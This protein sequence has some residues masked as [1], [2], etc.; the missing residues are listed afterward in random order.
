MTTSAA[1]HANP[2]VLRARVSDPVAPAWRRRT[3]Y[4]VAAALFVAALP[5][6]AASGNVAAALFGYAFALCIAGP[7]FAPRRAPEDVR[8]ELSHGRVDLV[9]DRERRTLRARGLVGASTAR[10]GDGR[11]ALA[12]MRPGDHAPMVLELE[13]EGAAAAVSRA[14]GIGYD[15]FG[16]L[17]WR[18]APRATE[19]LMPA[20]RAICAVAWA[21]VPTLMA[22][23]RPFEA[24]ASVAGFVGSALGLLM[25]LLVAV[26]GLFPGPSIA[27]TAGGVSV[28][29]HGGQVRALG[30]RQIQHL[31]V[32][33]EAMG[34]ATPGKLAEIVPT[35][36]GSR[37]TRGAMAP[38]QRRCL[39]AQV[40]TA[41]ARSRGEAPPRPEPV[42][43]ST[44][45]RRGASSVREWLARLDTMAAA[46]A[47]AATGG[48]YRDGTP[49]AEDDLWKVLDDTDADADARAGA[50]RV[51]VRV[52]PERAR[53]RI[54]QILDTV[55]DEGARTRI[56]VAAD[57]EAP[58]AVEE[59][60][61]MML[62]GG[63]RRG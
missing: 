35:L 46:I 32:E 16:F 62:G 10:L 50:A 23:G 4:L 51:L 40:E 48:G 34:F 33:H 5:V 11:V 53:P 26:D 49:L 30:W 6:S 18:T 47:H 21:L 12:L 45:L 61:V 14:L 60:E 9:T 15:G 41:L 38:E 52:A 43:R 36:G 20:L 19:R 3:P 29:T 56:R 37:F 44:F 58:H 57:T 63:T 25:L 13:N 24:I 39:L 54:A 2:S 8:V 17:S 42:A 7:L 1:T 31:L 59:L 55:H 28:R 27:L 22:L